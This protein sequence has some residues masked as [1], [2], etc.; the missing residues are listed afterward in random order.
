VPKSRASKTAPVKLVPLAQLKPHPRNPRRH[1][2]GEIDALNRDYRRLFQS[3]VKLIDS[4]GIK[5]G[6]RSRK[7]D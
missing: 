3:V 7:G 2:R 5:T 6:R 4:S 1:D